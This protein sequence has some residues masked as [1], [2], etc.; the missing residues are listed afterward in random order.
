M[1]VFALNPNT[2]EIKAQGREIQGH[3]QLYLGFKSSLGYG[4]LCLG[5]VCEEMGRIEII[6]TTFETRYWK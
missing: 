2:W 3:S 5:K 4:K 6:L 1:A